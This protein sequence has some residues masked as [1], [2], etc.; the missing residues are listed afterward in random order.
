M[1]INGIEFQVGQPIKCLI[2]NTPVDGAIFFDPSIYYDRC[3]ICHN[4]PEF[5]GSPSPNK[6]GFNFSWV[7]RVGGNSDVTNLIPL[8]YEGL[9]TISRV[10]SDKLSYLLNNIIDKRRYLIAFFCS[11]EPFEAFTDI[12]DSEKPGYII[13]KG[14][15]KRID[16]VQKEQTIAR[17]RTTIKKIE[18][19]LSRYLKKMSDAY[20][21]HLEDSSGA[22][23]EPLF[24]DSEIETI[25]N[26]FVGACN[27]DNFTLEFLSGDDIDFGYKSKNY[28]R[29]CGTLG[30]SCMSDKIDFLDIYR[31]NQN[32]S[33]AVLKI[34]NL[35]DARCIVW[36]INGVKFFDRIYST[37]DW[38]EQTMRKKLKDSGCKPLS[39]ENFIEI[40]LDNYQFEYY[41][42]LDS[43]RHN[44]D[45]T[46]RFFYFTEDG[47]MPRGYYKYFGSTQGSYAT[48][49]Y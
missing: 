39:E 21:K 48:L 42:Y 40:R 27:C 31:K 12:L 24:T 3:W 4:D 5:D 18:I 28:S 37:Y 15:F 32:C 22:A 8:Q 9:M 7:F 34:S 45:G 19:K 25:Y 23:V 1:L 30:K 17:S 49:N 44:L 11:L 38:I 43:F 46:N 13:L 6:L 47:K 14:S 33:L 41:P 20:I 36:E 10:L 29:L 26:K 2:K 16:A 35:V